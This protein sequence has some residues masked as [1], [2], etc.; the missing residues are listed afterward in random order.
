METFENYEIFS[1]LYFSYVPDYKATLSRG[2]KKIGIEF[3][4]S[5]S[6]ITKIYAFVLFFIVVVLLFLNILEGC[7]LLKNLRHFNFYRYSDLLSVTFSVLS[8]FIKVTVLT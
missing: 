7:S 4:I 3:T 1:N 2:N 5:M 6:W 8:F